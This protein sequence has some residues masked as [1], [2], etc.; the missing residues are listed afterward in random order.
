MSAYLNLVLKKKILATTKVGDGTHDALEQAERM[1]SNLHH[2]IN[3]EEGR[4]EIIDLPAPVDRE[5]MPE[6][7]T[8]LRIVTTA[9]PPQ[10]RK[11]KDKRRVAP[12][13]WI[14]IRDHYILI[15][16]FT[17]PLAETLTNVFVEGRDVYNDANIN[18]L[19]AASFDAFAKHWNLPAAE[20]VKAF[21]LPAP[22]A[23]RLEK[24]GVRIV[25]ESEGPLHRAS[26]TSH[27]VTLH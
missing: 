25:R 3:I 16:R 20:L 22:Y 10:G 2:F 12:D 21:V 13:R 7:I 4:H 27:T 11:I 18:E 26:D 5:S 15:D 9:E 1:I 17:R 23:W 8:P 24:N 19:L 14:G 6:W